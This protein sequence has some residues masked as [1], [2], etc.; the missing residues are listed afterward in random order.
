MTGHLVGVSAEV[1]VSTSS[2]PN[3]FVF[4]KGYLESAQLSVATCVEKQGHRVET[5]PEGKSELQYLVTAIPGCGFDVKL[6]YGGGGWGIITPFHRSKINI[7]FYA[8]LVVIMTAGG[9]LF[10]GYPSVLLV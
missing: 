7:I 6:L 3:T 10:G 8:F 1:I 5:S 9:V 2:L 4:S